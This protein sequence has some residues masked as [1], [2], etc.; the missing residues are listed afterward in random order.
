MTFTVVLPL[1]PALVAV[2][3]YVVIVD[4]AVGVPDIV[5]VVVSNDKPAGNAGLID[6]LV[7]VPPVLVGLHVATAVLMT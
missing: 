5:P 7:A 3:V 4:N 6:Q 2:M 1:P